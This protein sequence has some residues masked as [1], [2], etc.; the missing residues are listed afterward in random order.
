LDDGEK[1]KETAKRKKW[2]VF[3]GWQWYYRLAAMADLNAKSK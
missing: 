3:S 2:A 1:G